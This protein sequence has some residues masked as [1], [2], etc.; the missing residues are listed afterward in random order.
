MY[1]SYSQ[2]GNA[3][4][5]GAAWCAAIAGTSLWLAACGVQPA[6]SATLPPPSMSPQTMPPPASQPSQRVAATGWDGTYRGTADVRLTG[7]GRCFQNQRVTDFRV[8]G[9]QA[10][11]Q[12]FRGR[13]DPDGSVQMHFGHDWIIGRFDG[14]GG[15]YGQLSI[16]NWGKSPSCSWI[17]RLTRVGS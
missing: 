9:N 7:G 15:F 5:R 1:P 17:L 8:R 3:A 11:Y 6:E 10:T 14:N 16:D 4:F 13:I 12:G 2:S